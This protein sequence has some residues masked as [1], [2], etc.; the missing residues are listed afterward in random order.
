MTYSSL[1]TGSRPSSLAITFRDG[2]GPESFFTEKLGLRFSGTGR[3]RE[4]PR[5]FSASKS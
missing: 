2:I 5:A 4:W 1:S 3:N